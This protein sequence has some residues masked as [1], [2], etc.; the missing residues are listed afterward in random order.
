LG[1]LN[2][3]KFE[4]M[5][6]IRPIPVA[7]Q[8]NEVLRSRIRDRTYSPGERLPSE[9]DLSKDFGVSRAT[10]RTVLARLESEGLILRKQGD[11]TYINEHIQ[12]VNTH[13]GGLWEFS[14]L[15]ESSGFTPSIECLSIVTRPASNSE[16]L[17]LHIEESSPVLALKR[18]F[19]ADDSP[20]ILVANAIPYHFL[21]SDSEHFDGQ[22]NIRD[23]L[24]RYCHRK[25]AYAISEVRAE[26]LSEEQS[27]Y[28]LKSNDP[29]LHINIT[30]YDR[31][32]QPLVSGN[33]YYDASVLRLRLVQAWS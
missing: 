7:D 4:N 19:Y 13:L 5:N 6:I 12:D 22:M 28:L 18:L 33:S 24:K 29:F 27:E 14:L 25:I 30:F 31:D 11:G 15:I 8:V 17:A 32:N 2:L 21:D 23:F 1:F 20:V 16:S 3:S 9:S 26:N 10:V